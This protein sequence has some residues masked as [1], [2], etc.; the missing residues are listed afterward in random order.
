MHGSRSVF[1]S[2]H[3]V[4]D[5]QLAEGAVGSFVVNSS[6]G[7]RRTHSSDVTNSITRGPTGGGA[8]SKQDNVL[9]WN[10]LHPQTAVVEPETFSATSPPP[11]PSGNGSALKSSVIV[12][13]VVVLVVVVGCLGADQSPLK[14]KEMFDTENK[15]GVHYKGNVRCWGPRATAPSH[16]LIKTRRLSGSE[17]G[18][19]SEHQTQQKVAEI[20][21]PM[22]QLYRGI[23]AST[24]DRLASKANLLER[25]P[26]GLSIH[27][28]P[29]LSQQ[30]HVSEAMCRGSG[31]ANLPLNLRGTVSQLRAPEGLLYLESSDIT[32]ELPPLTRR[33]ANPLNVFKPTRPSSEPGSTVARHPRVKGFTSSAHQR[34]CTPNPPGSAAPC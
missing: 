10:G 17:S 2:R 24:A 23:L 28:T 14:K 29:K 4:R 12:M 5:E 9:T 3:E 20:I 6:R 7:N 32:R 11:L 25:A 27:R 34:A 8:T 21:A 1:E 15:V 33:H 16:V 13:V 22:I 19:G 30:I 18:D 26:R 31:E